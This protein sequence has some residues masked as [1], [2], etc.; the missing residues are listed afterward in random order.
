VFI[1]SKSAG[2]VTAG[3]GMIV[4]LIID[5]YFS[6]FVTKLFVRPIAKVLAEGSGVANE[7]AGYKS[8][9]ESKW[10]TLIGSTLAVA[11]STVLYIVMVLQLAW[12]GHDGEMWSNKWLNVFVFG[13]SANSILNTVG[14]VLVCGVLKR[15]NRAQPAVSPGPG[16]GAAKQTE[17][18]ADSQASSGYSPSELQ[19][20]RPVAHAEEGFQ[21]QAPDNFVSLL[22]YGSKPPEGPYGCDNR[23]EISKSGSLGT[24]LD[25]G[26]SCESDSQSDSEGA[27]KLEST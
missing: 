21:L 1:F 2:K 11:S 24:R 6:V 7:S 25:S 13:A 3:F 18:Q 27:S 9:L 17:F 19:L 10:Y 8:M 20:E 14:M 16:A 22:P 26:G 15:S 23:G 12:G 4:V 5:T